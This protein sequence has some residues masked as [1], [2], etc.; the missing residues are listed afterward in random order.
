ML[1][2]ELHK[3]FQPIRVILFSFCVLFV[4]LLYSDFFLFAQFPCFILSTDS[5]NTLSQHALFKLPFMQTCV[6]HAF[7]LHKIDSKST[8]IYWQRAMYTMAYIKVKV[9]SFLVV[10]WSECGHPVLLVKS[11][12]FN[13]SLVFA[14][15]G[16]YYLA[17]QQFL[18]LASVSSL[19]MHQYLICISSTRILNIHT[20]RSKRS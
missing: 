20:Q 12:F 7:D 16:K 11:F 17:F 6:G 3:Y 8:P 1:C 9:E 5:H 2:S 13:F 19:K 10:L 15:C 4:Q 18:R 14:V